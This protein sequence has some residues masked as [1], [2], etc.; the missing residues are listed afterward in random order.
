M[1][2]PTTDIMVIFGKS[3]NINSR[4]R[5]LK[6]L[7]MLTLCHFSMIQAKGVRLV[8]LLLTTSREKNNELL[9][10]PQK[11]QSLMQ[12]RRSNSF[13]GFPLLFPSITVI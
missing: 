9:K 12:N 6:N 4:V 10:M 7:Q 3:F 11:Q 5:L 1:K 2:K 8:S 13:F